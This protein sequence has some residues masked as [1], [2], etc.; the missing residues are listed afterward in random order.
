MNI[1]VAAWTWDILT[2]W[3]T[4]VSDSVS[5]RTLQK[6]L[7]QSTIVSSSSSNPKMKK[8]KQKQNIPCQENE[9]QIPNENNTKMIM[10]AKRNLKRPLACLKISSFAA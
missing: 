6:N 2:V 4:F 8:K 5:C 10:I 9:I 3:L 1:H 7:L